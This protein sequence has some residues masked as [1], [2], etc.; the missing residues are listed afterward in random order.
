M[1]K[2]KV[3]TLWDCLVLQYTSSLKGISKYS[4]DMGQIIAKC[5]SENTIPFHR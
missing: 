5:E 3:D 2:V 1:E 4:N